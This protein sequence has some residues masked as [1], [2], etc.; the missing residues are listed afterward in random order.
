MSCPLPAPPKVCV[1]P[2]GY[3]DAGLPAG[4][5]VTTY[6]KA[7]INAQ[8]YCSGVTGEW[9]YNGV[10]GSRA[11]DIA[12]NG[13]NLGRKYINGC[14]KQHAY[15][16]QVVCKRKTYTGDRRLCCFQDYAFNSCGE[17]NAE[18]CFDG[19]RTC[20]PNY[21]NVLNSECWDEVVSYCTGDNVEPGSWFNRWMNSKGEP[22]ERV[23]DQSHPDADPYKGICMYAVRR[24]LFTRENFNGCADVPNPTS[25]VCG[26]PL[27]FPIYTDGYARVQDLIRKVMLRYNQDGYR[28]GANPGERGYSDFQRFIYRYLCCAYPGI[29]RSFLQQNCAQYSGSEVKNNPLLANWCGCYLSPEVYREYV[30]KYQLNP[31]CTPYCNRVGTLPLTDGSGRVIPCTQNICIIDD[32]SLS[33][34]QTQ[35]GGEVK[36]SNVC[37]QCPGGSCS[38]IIQGTTIDISDTII[39]GDVLLQNNCGNRSCQLP[40]SGTENEF[41][42]VPCDATENPMTDIQDVMQSAKLWEYAT[43]IGILGIFTVLLVGLVFFLRRPTK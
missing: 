8:G 14:D 39:G 13:D 40:G 28:I 42:P 3:I 31:E 33:L 9:E 41:I 21:R 7:E 29:C 34:W 17:Q 19:I 1:Q 12:L 26:A 20:S 27:A 18:S 43:Y 38:C 25:K 37:G 6:H 24:A 11:I 30:D 16:A 5:S 22:Q 23:Y 32:V 10:D 15:G 4:G 35:I 36:F 2:V